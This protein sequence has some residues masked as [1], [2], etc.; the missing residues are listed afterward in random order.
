METYIMPVPLYRYRILFSDGE[1]ADVIAP[2]DSSNMRE[3]VLLRYKRDFAG[4][5]EP[6]ISGVADLGLEKPPPTMEVPPE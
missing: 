5:Y 1:C 4:T 3:Y 2:R 6:V